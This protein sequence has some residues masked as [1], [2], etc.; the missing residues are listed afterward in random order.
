MS[1]TQTQQHEFPENWKNI[2][3]EE[4]I[5]HIKYLLE[6]IQEYEITVRF[7]NY[8]LVAGISLKRLDLKYCKY[9]SA[10]PGFVV[11]SQQTYN[12]V[13]KKDIYQL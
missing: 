2:S 13:Q 4:A 11:N 10:F 5:E 8:V 6:H 9:Y 1:E 12:V 3:D 7:D